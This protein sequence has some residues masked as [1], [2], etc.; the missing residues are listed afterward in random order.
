M[1]AESNQ[2]DSRSGAIMVT[3]GLS[4]L[5]PHVYLDT[6]LLLG[7]IGGQIAV[8]GRY[9]FGV[10]ASIASF[11]WFLGLIFGARKL[12]PL[13]AK[14]YTWRLLDLLVAGVMWSIAASLWF[15][16]YHMGLPKAF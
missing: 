8:P 5:N 10:G 1:G 11:I 15:K 14:A 4:L 6:V 9:W 12:A 3:M 2:I 16:A 7:S 13:F